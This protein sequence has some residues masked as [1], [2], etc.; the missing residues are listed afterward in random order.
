MADPNYTA[1]NYQKKD[2][3]VVTQVGIPNPD[4]L[5]AEASYYQYLQMKYTEPRTDTGREIWISPS[6]GI[7]YNT[8]DTQWSDDPDIFNRGEEGMMNLL[9]KLYADNKGWI[10]TAS[11]F[12]KVAK[13]IDDIMS[14]TL[15]VYSS[16]TLNGYSFEYFATKKSVDDILNGNIQ[17]GNADKLD[18][19]HA[20]AFC[21]ASQYNNIINGTTKVGN[22]NKLDGFDSSYFATSSGLISANQ[23]IANIVS[24]KTKVASAT[25]ADSA[26]FAETAGNA[27][28]ISGHTIDDFLTSDNAVKTYY[29]TGTPSTSLG[30]D[31]DIYVQV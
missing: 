13:T 24:G 20:S 15:N 8:N 18:G 6:S 17:L 30:K 4:N 2:L 29:G 1:M 22:A 25:K 28:T 14:G 5:S 21:L 19:Y 23:S 16:L 3:P 27:N 7:T 26:T 12:N 9:H 11:D 10:L 31:G